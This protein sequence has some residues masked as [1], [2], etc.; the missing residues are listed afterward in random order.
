MLLI[1]LH[2]SRL[3]IS[4]METALSIGQVAKRTGLIIDTFYFERIGLIEPVSRTHNGNRQYRQ[5]AIDHR[6]EQR[7]TITSPFGAH[8]T[9]IEVIAGHDL[10]GKTALVAGASSGMGIEM[11]PALLWAHVEVILAVRDPAKG[12][13]IAQPGARQQA[14]LRRISFLYYTPV[15][16]S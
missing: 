15:F 6:K 5:E 2:N 7:M 14:M 16:E 8:S 4:G 11:A 13:H 10:S 3:Y 9:A 12:E 1:K